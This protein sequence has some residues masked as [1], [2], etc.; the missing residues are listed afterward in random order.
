MRLARI[1]VPLLAFACGNSHQPVGDILVVASSL[2]ANAQITRVTASISPADVKQDLNRNA[3]GTFSGSIVVPVGAQTVTVEAFVATTKV[4]TGT[5][6]VTVTKGAHMQALITILD[7]TGPDG[8]PD[9]SPVVTSLVTPTAMQVDDQSVVTAT[10]ADGDSDSIAFAW[11]ASPAGCVTFT[12]P[13]ASST[14]ATA[15]AISAPCTLTITVTANGKSDSKSAPVQISAATGSIDVTVTY[16]PQPRIGSIALSDSTGQIALVLRNAADATIRAPFHKGIPYTVTVTF[17]PW[18]AG[19]IAL[20]DSCGGVI[21]Q[22]VF[23]ANGTSASGTWTPSVD[24]GTCNLTATLTRVAPPGAQDAGS[25][26]D[27][28]FVVVLPVP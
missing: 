24:T 11:T 2:T 8:K 10:A 20:S 16:V 25:L 7:T 12:N 17:D 9:H 18:P 28:W 23:P 26:V 3:D 15:K 21:A 1:C 13:A 6:T 14:I 22:P 27:S 5:A 19:A 4:G